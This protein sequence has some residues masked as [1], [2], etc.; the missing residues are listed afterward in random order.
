M[1]DH[2]DAVFYAFLV[3]AFPIIVLELGRFMWFFRDDW[4]FIAERELEL[5]DLFRPHNAHWST[6]PITIFRGLYSAFGLRTYLPYMAIVVALHLSIV[7]TI[8]VVM[9]RSGVGRWVA[10]LFAGAFVFFGPGRE[11]I[12]W[13]FQIGFTGAVAAVLLQ[14]VLADHDGPADRRD[15]LG[16]AAGLVGLM[17]SSSAVVMVAVGGGALLVRRG[18]RRAL[19]HTAPLAIA[20]VVYDL[21]ADPLN[22]ST[23]GF[24]AGVAVDWVRNGF[25]AG[26]LAIGHYRV[27]VGL[28]VAVLVA[29]L[30][31]HVATQRPEGPPTWWGRVRE[32]AFP[33][34]L[35]AG[36]V[37]FIVL[38]ARSR[39]YQGPRGARAS[40]YVYFYGLALLPV[41]A[42]ASSALI[43]RWRALAPIVLLVVVA[44]PANLGAFDDPPFGPNYHAS[45]RNVLTAVVALPEARQV[46]PGLR[47]IPDPFMGDGVTIGFLL[48]A[49]AAGKMDAP[50]QRIPPL[51]RNELL[52]RLSLEQSAGG[53][54]PFCTLVTTSEVRIE[55]EV[56]DAIGL[57]GPVTVQLVR[58]GEPV[59]PRVGFDPIGGNLLEVALPD[60]ELLILPAGGAA[61]PAV[62]PL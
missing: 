18:W 25:S 46:D 40:R 37:L 30:V 57:R 23:A 29:G 48:D 47:P 39:S 2:P 43:R 8:R 27:V 32:V 36:M 21:L 56:G 6:V 45:R 24:G 7:A 62:C 35:L 11:D 17:S 49:D 51:L 22:E 44:V 3:A 50:P 20:Y 5:D 60:V 53:L 38:A 26:F 12:I 41:L 10:N 42:V 54:L 52:V 13:A 15:A 33:L 59:P 1:R 58:D 4:L 34:A 28:L 16:L 9:V 55:A 61:T 31:V 14:M 19:L